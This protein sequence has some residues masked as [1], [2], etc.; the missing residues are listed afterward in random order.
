VLSTPCHYVARSFAHSLFLT[1]TPFAL[2]VYVSLINMVFLCSIS[3][4]HKRNAFWK[5][6]VQVWIEGVLSS[7]PI[8]PKVGWAY[9][10]L[11]IFVFKCEAPSHTFLFLFFF[12][13]L[14]FVILHDPFFHCYCLVLVLVS[15]CSFLVVFFFYVFCYI[16]RLVPCLHFQLMLMLIYFVFAIVFPR[17]V[18]RSL[19]AYLFFLFLEGLEHKKKS[20][21]EY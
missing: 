10:Y 7:K 12:F 6:V 1:L 11:C 13:F 19:E 20:S 14:C 8:T 5:S 15:I 2:C 17:E 3:L 9:L 4:E 18:L 21:K 16:D